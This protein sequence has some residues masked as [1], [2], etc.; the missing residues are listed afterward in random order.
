LAISTKVN[1]ELRQVGSTS[2]LI[3]NVTQIIEF[4]SQ[5]NTLVANSIILIGT[6][7]SVGMAMNP[8]RWLKPGDDV[9]ITVDKIGTLRH[10][11]KSAGDE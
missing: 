1:K 5:G 2:G 3:F 9:E 8:P 11:I 4:R 7:A 6:P 10:W